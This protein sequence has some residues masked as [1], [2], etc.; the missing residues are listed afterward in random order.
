MNEIPKLTAKEWGEKTTKSTHIMRKT[1]DVSQ[2]VVT[3][4]VQEEAKTANSTEQVKQEQGEVESAKAVEQPVEQIEP[5]FPFLSKVKDGCVN[6][7]KFVG[8]QV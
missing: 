1:E 5:R 6:F 2:I 7:A 3:T 4:P 8:R